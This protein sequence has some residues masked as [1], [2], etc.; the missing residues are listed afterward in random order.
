M[1]AMMLLFWGGLIALGVWA[2]RALTAGRT[3]GNA[4]IEILRRRLAA[5]EIS[6]E[7]FEKTKKALGA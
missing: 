6:Q 1:S 3:G 5:G 7:E 4:A 2:I